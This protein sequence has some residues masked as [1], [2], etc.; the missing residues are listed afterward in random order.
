MHIHIHWAIDVS[1]RGGELTHSYSITEPLKTHIAPSKN[2]P[3]DPH[4][5]QN[6]NLQ[7]INCSLKKTTTT[8]TKQKKAPTPLGTHT[9]TNYIDYTSL[10]FIESWTHSSAYVQT[11]FWFRRISRTPCMTYYAAFSKHLPLV[12]FTNLSADG[13]PFLCLSVLNK[14]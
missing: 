13:S 11:N 1:L 4:T 2:A 3:T 14:T 12:I 5:Y 10:L 6:Q 7:N 9:I 8:I